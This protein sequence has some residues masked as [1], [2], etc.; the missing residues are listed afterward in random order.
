MAIFPPGESKEDW[1]I[2]RALSE[3]LNKK[4]PYDTLEQV[5]ERM[6]KIN[7]I[8]LKINMINTEKWE[9]FG[10]TNS[11]NDINFNNVIK[12]YYMTDT[13]SRCSVT[14]AK[15]ANEFGYLSSKK[16]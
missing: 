16:I 8:F 5:R 11:I 10:I 2:I 3:V 13:I 15:C 12:N 9:P 14:M 7:K 4:L 6:G 1:T